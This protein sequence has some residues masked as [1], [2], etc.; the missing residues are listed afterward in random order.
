MR[1]AGPAAL[2][3]WYVNTGRWSLEGRRAFGLLDN[4]ALLCVYYFASGQHRRCDAQ[5][6]STPL[7]FP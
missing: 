7:G 5:S 3:R 6:F 2:R 4:L 1:D